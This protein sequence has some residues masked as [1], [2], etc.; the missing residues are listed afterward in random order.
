MDLER[1][2]ELISRAPTEEIL[3]QDELRAL[4]E[5]KEHPVAYDGFEPSGIAHLGSGLLRAIKLQDMV[6]AGIKF[7]L[8]VA[9]WYAWINNKMGG[10]L[11]KI[12]QAGKYL[13]EAWK[14]CGVDTKKV[15][16]VWTSDVVKDPEYWKLVIDVAKMTTINR[17]IR[18][19]TVMGREEKEMQYTAQILYPTMQTADPFYLKADICQLGMDQRKCTILSREVGPKIGKWVPVCV[20]HHLL[21]GLQGPARMGKEEFD[22]NKYLKYFDELN[23][24]LSSFTEKFKRLDEKNFSKEKIWFFRKME[25]KIHD[26]E[27][28]SKR[29]HNLEYDFKQY[30]QYFRNL[31]EEVYLEFYKYLKELELVITPTPSN[32]AVGR[33][34]VFFV[35]YFEKADNFNI[36]ILEKINEVKEQIRIESKMSKSKPMTA[37]F[38]HDTPE[39]IKKKISA[40]FCPEKQVEENPILEISKYIIFR[41]TDTLAISRPAKFGGNLELQGF[42]ELAKIYCEGKLHPMDLKSAVAEELIRILEPV[43]AYFEKNKEAK[44]LFEA[45]RKAN[46][47][48]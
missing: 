32:P 47:T 8:L 45:I 16:I 43:R 30:P 25:S 24:K 11:S 18:A 17:M 2:I 21:K 33:I 4:L 19:S 31:V 6:D 27:N 39:E 36:N 23:K 37:I 3:T 41:K 44:E 29:I 22:T 12:Q 5:T 46:V 34:G 42:D 35:E 9:D 20:H 40:A 13:I 7:K 10:D 48:R 38:I 15:E 26:V 1:K 28:W 14:A